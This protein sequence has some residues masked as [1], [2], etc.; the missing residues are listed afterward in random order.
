MARQA[1]QGAAAFAQDRRGLW[2]RPAPVPGLPD[3]PSRRAAG[4]R[5]DSSPQAAGHPRSSWPPAAWRAVT[6]PLAD[7]PARG[8]A[9]L[10]PPSRAGGSRHRLG[11]RGDPHPEGREAPAAPA[12]ACRTRSRSPTSGRAPAR[13]ASPGS[14]PATPRCCRCSTERACASRRRSAS[15][16]GTRRSAAIDVADGH[17]QG[18]QGAHRAGNPADPAGGRGVSAAV[19]LHRC[20]RRARCSSARAA[21]RSRRASSSSRWRSCAARS[22][23]PTARRRTRCAIPSRPIS[24]PRGGDLRGIQE[25]LGHA[26]L[27]TTQLYTKVDAARLM[28]AFDAAHP[29]ARVHRHSGA[30]QSVEPGTHKR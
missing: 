29:R 11:L 28:E 30:T 17:R 18:R 12:L 3:R 21:G 25:L 16:A 14:W 1:R 22:G 27:S 8:L 4:D 26:S 9:L 5:S 24:S 7:A 6:E 2:P 23:F 10:R 19:P 13:R 20:R 15:S